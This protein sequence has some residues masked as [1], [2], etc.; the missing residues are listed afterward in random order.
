M[1]NKGC[2]HN[3]GLWHQRTDWNGFTLLPEKT[4][5]ICSQ[6]EKPDT[7]WPKLVKIAAILQHCMTVN[8]KNYPLGIAQNGGVAKQ[9]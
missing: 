9:Q 4:H 1:Q 3:L 8:L 2:V 7:L 5:K 6:A